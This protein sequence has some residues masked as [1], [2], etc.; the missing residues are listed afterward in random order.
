VL[1]FF[2]V[3]CAL[4]P[5]SPVEVFEQA[6][7]AYGQVAER[8]L[9]Y[10]KLCQEAPNPE[11]MKRSVRLNAVNTEA[12]EKLRVGRLVVAGLPSIETECDETADPGCTER[13]RAEQL[14]ALALLLE[15]LAFRLNG[16][17][18]GG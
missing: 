12:M 9:L 18:G 15:G 2:F 13:L 3:A 1:W 8:A 10:M 16:A 7:L 4:L 6:E 14:R 5:K 11:C 17:L